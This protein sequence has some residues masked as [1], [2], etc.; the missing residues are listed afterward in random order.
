M[1]GDQMRIAQLLDNL[2]SN[3]I[4]VHPAGRAGRGAERAS[5]ATRS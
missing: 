3:A 5:K 1:S 2:V 4:E